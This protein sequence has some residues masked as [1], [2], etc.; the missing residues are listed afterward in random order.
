VAPPPPTAG[1]LSAASGKV[2]ALRR[3]V[4][5]QSD[6]TATGERLTGLTKIGAD[7]ISGDSGGA[8]YDG[9]GQVVGMTTAA[10]S[11]ANDVVGYVVPIG[12]VVSIAD[13]LENGVARTRYAYGMP[14]F[15]G[16]GLGQRGTTVQGVYRGTPAA[17]AGIVSGD[18]I[19]AVDGTAAST[20]EQLHALIAQ[21]S[22]GGS[23][24]VTWTDRTGASHTATVT[25][26]RGPV[27]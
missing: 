13:D 11:G 19:T 4:T 14:A 7:V 1:F 2:L 22:V 16:V 20:A 15:L 26:G 8:T 18:R 23:A 21:H 10:S 12:K 9:D 24:A 25:L 27:E 3:S 6:G 17:R 5:T